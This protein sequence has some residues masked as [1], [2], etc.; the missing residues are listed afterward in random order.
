MVS[1]LYVCFLQSLR[2][3][4][5][6]HC[7]V[8]FLFLKKVIIISSILDFNIDNGAVFVC[9]FIGQFLHV[10]TYTYSGVIAYSEHLLLVSVEL[11]VIFFWNSNLQWIYWYSKYQ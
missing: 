3:I 7:L 2:R 8:S 1:I 6:Y 4:D 11:L 5:N 10:S 9:K